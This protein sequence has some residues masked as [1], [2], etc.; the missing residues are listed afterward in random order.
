MGIEYQWFVGIDW[1]TEKND[2]CVVDSKGVR[3][4][5]FQ[6][7]NSPEGMS[8]LCN[9]LSDQCSSDIDSM[10]V[11]IEIPH[12]AI[13]ECLADRGFHVFSINPKQ[14][15]RFRDR[16]CP[17]GSKDDKLDAF[18]LADSV[19]TDIHCF[20]RIKIQAADMIILRELARLLGDLGETR[21][22]LTNRLRQQIFRFAP[23]L[24]ELSPS[25]D[26]GWFWS[27]LDKKLSSSDTKALSV[28]DITKILKTH[29]IRKLTG[30]D[31]FLVLQKP[32]LQVAPGTV[33]AATRHIRALVEQLRLIQDQHRQVKAELEE[34]MENLS[35]PCEGGEHRDAAIIVSLPGVGSIVA[36]T[37]LSEAAQAIAER[38]YAAL[39]AHAGIAPVTKRSGKRLNVIM[40]K[41]CN[42]R[43]RNALYHWCRVSV[44]KDLVSRAKYAA[45]RAK[46]HSHGRA[47]RT[48]GDANLRVLFGM[49]KSNSIFDPERRAVA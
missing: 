29:R 43:L 48:V 49:L 31:A 36:A 41:A 35:L 21:N 20:R 6:F 37:I 12:G 27:L 26:E 25:A 14:L 33:M 22:R 16:H 40:R 45:M 1:A 38:D 10:A 8:F 24:L 32:Y 2:V 39:R 46:G 7:P 11:S 9:T 3:K 4:A 44:Q 5:E 28:K 30:P 17:A 42:E 34:V 18:V 19:R 47:L 23:H 13:V 15:D